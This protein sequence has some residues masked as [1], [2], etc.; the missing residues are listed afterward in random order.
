MLFQKKAAPYTPHTPTP[1]LEPSER[2]HHLIPVIERAVKR[3]LWSCQPSDQEDATQVGLIEVWA[4]LQEPLCRENTDSWFVTRAVAYARDYARRLVYRYHR[5]NEAIVT[6]DDGDVSTPSPVNEPAANDR[7]AEIE[8]IVYVTELMD[9][10]SPIQRTIAMRLA[11]GERKTE[12][13][14]SL[15]LSYKAVIY[16]CDKI[17]VA[18]A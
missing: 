9:G 2:F 5:R 11:A 18:L 13:A 15:G 3:A 1:Q 8:D 6:F 10:L 16:Q 7:I 4:K 12:I 17:A 14:A